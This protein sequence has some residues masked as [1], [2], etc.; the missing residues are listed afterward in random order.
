MTCLA[1]RE[2][3]LETPQDGPVPVEWRVHLEHC[4]ECREWS[5]D[6]DAMLDG[7]RSVPVPD[8]PPG[9]ESRLSHRLRAEADRIRRAP[10]TRAR[11]ILRMAQAAVAASLA[12]LAWFA[13]KP[14][15]PAGTCVRLD[16]A[17]AARVDL[18]GV[19]TSVD[20]PGGLALARPDGSALQARGLRWAADL[21]AGRPQSWSVPLVAPG[22]G[23]WS[24]RMTTRHGSTSVYR[25]VEVRVGAG[26]EL[27]VRWEKPVLRGAMGGLALGPANV[28]SHGG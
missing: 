14:S 6:L 17:V 16:V 9:F 26:G 5:L 11:P 13:V 12:A 15:S 20:L 18:A 22:P 28:S 27:A 1:H 4:A 25:I 2:R 19:E 10:R 24:V 3:R 8:L 7:L 21:A 23:T